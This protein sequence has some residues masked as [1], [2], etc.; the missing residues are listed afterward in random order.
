MITKH[1]KLK[2]VLLRSCEILFPVLLYDTRAS[3]LPTL[4]AT[5]SKVRA[6]LGPLILRRIQDDRTGL[7]P[8]YRSFCLLPYLNRQEANPPSSIRVHFFWAHLYVWVCVCVFIYFFHSVFLLSF[9]ISSFVSFFLFFIYFSPLLSLFPRASTC[10]VVHLHSY[11][12]VCLSLFFISVRPVNARGL[13][14]PSV[15]RITLIP[16][17]TQ[18][19][20]R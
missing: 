19:K 10:F 3:G 9:I 17:R 15:R 14:S 16:L 18:D 8:W 1:R 5:R 11:S 6:A 7:L 2:P 20:M 13:N 12:F 4:W